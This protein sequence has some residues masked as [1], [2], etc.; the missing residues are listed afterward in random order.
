MILRNDSPKRCSG[1]LSIARTTTGRK[2]VRT[3]THL[4]V[5]FTLFTGDA[6]DRPKPPVALPRSNVVNDSPNGDG[7]NGG[8]DGFPSSG[9]EPPGDADDPTVSLD[10][11]F[12]I[13]SKHRCRYVLSCLEAT[14]VDV[15]ELDDLV[16]HV[17][18]R[19]AAAEL[20]GATDDHHQR[21]AATLHHCHLPKLSNTAILDY[22]ARS[23]TIRYRGNDRVAAYLDAFQTEG[24]P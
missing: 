3:E 24:E 10:T 4:S 11:L 17:V 6:P 22:D 15:V 9:P 16:E 19:E 7:G 8:G 21:V 2:V 20:G 5:D 18:E 1:S 14:P 23:K 13:L 12:E